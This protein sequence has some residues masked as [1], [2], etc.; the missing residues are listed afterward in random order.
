MEKNYF[1]ILFLIWKTKSLRMGD[2]QI[3]LRI[4]VDG[5]RSEM[6]INRTINPYM[7]KEKKTLKVWQNF[8]LLKNIT[9]FATL[10]I[11][12]LKQQNY[13]E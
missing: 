3:Y 8:W 11:L 9:I 4:T 1:T 13:G 6:K 5:R 12:I 2:T 10:L 7:W